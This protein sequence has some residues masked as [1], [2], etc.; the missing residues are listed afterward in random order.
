MKQLLLPIALLVMLAPGYAQQNRDI[1]SL[2]NIVAKVEGEAKIEALGALSGLLVVGQPDEAL[3]YAYEM[4]KLAKQYKQED[5]LLTAWSLRARAYQIKTDFDSLQIISRNGILLSRQMENDSLLGNF[6]NFMGIY[7]EKTVSV[8][9]AIHY[10]KLALLTKGANT[11]VLY[12]NL[13]LAYRRKGAFFQSIK[14]LELALGEAQRMKNIGLEAIV[15]NNIGMIHFDLGNEDRAEYYYNRSIEL[16]GQI[17]DERGKLFALANMLRLDNPLDIKEDYIERA[18]RILEKIDHPFLHRLFLMKRANLLIGKGEY[19]E[20]SNIILPIYQQGNQDNGF[21]LMEAA[22]SLADIHY[23]L[24]EFEEA[25]KYALEMRANARE[26]NDMEGIQGAQKKLLKIYAENRDYQQYFEIAKDYY[27]TRDSMQQ[28]AMLNKLAYLDNSM[29]NAEQEKEIEELNEALRQK[30]I[31]RYWIIGVSSLIGLILLLIIYFRNRQVVLERKAARELARLNE[32]LKSLDAL[33][34]RFFTNI[35]H[36]LRTPV[37]LIF[38]PL[39]Q[40][41][42]KY[43]SSLEAELGQS[44]K[45]ARNN[46]RKLLSLVEELLDLSR[47][48]ANKLQL[49]EKPTSLLIFCR[50]LFSSFESKAA[51]KNIRYTFDGDLEEEAQYWVDRKRLEKIVNNLLS[52]AL[53]FTPNNGQVSLLVKKRK[54]GVQI[55]VSDTGRGIP[56]E[57][58][59]HVFERYFQT[60]R[61]SIATEGGTGVGLALSKELAGLMEGELSVESEWGQGSTFT[62]RIPARLLT[63]REMNVQQEGPEPRPSNMEEGIT[64]PAVL[65]AVTDSSRPKVLIVEDNPDM[66][67]LVHALLVDDYDCQIANNGAE[68]WSWMNNGKISPEDIDLILSDIMMP[69]MDGYALLQLLKQHPDWQKCPVIMLTA[70]ASEEDK[71]QALRM[72]VDDYLLKPFSPDELLARVSNLIDNYKR[73]QAFLQEERPALDIE[74]ESLESADQQWLQELEMAAKSALEKRLGLSA[75]YLAGQMALSE[76]QMRRQIQALTGLSSKQYIQEVKLQKARHL[77][78]NKAFNTISEVSYACGFNTP[79]YFSTLFK[80]HFGKQPG[81]YFS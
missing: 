68:A 23:E 34:S 78:E 75:T 10:Y 59:P 2:K 50:Q 77:L 42:R 14:H 46:A 41:L 65:P 4:E 11:L 30:E 73:R 1:D 37:T 58:M 47:L 70:R 63:E 8:D 25:E 64:A 26:M 51:M 39:E 69:E 20:A 24:R 27:P 57:D 6:Y 9:S 72:G 28:K 71:L 7:H 19:E 22:G 79:G 76:R 62:L 33:K 67:Q 31:R 18:M 12:S 80:K 52:N 81:D 54:D 66:Q 44:L 49:E 61:E 29:K 16:K 45:I 21:E 3:Q 55:Q 5:K 56:P 40:S 48:E 38:T 35:S 53:K 36:E 17:G 15:S 43:A 32:E 13:G 74:F 60:K